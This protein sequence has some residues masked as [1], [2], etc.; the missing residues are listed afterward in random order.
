MSNAET[1]QKKLVR[2]A[3][4]ICAGEVVFFIGAGFSLDSEGNTTKLLIARLLARFDALTKTLM[5]HGDPDAKPAAE[6]LR[7]GLRKTFA[8]PEEKLAPDLFDT[9]DRGQGRGSVLDEVLTTLSQGQNYYTINDW[10]CSAFDNLVEPMLKKPPADFADTVNATEKELLARYVQ[11]PRVTPIDL[12]WLARLRDDVTV[13]PVV[14]PER[15]VCG[16]ALFLDTLGFNDENVMSGQPYHAE[17]SKVVTT[18]SRVRTRH[19]VLSWLAAEGLCPTLVTTNYDLLVDCAHRL[20]GLLPLDPSPALWCDPTSDPLTKAARLQLPLNRRYRHFTRIAEADHFFSRGDAYG[21]ATIHKIHGCVETYRTARR[22]NDV[23]AFRKVLRTIVFTFREIQNWRT[24][25]WSRDHLTTLL[26]T[27]TIVFVGYSAADQVI[28]DTFRTVYEEIAQYRREA[29]SSQPKHSPGSTAR[30]FFMDLDDVRGFHGLEILRSASTAAGDPTKELGEHPNL[31]TFFPTRRDGTQLFPTLD[32]LFTWTYHLTARELQAQALATEIHSMTYQLFRQRK[33]RQETQAIIDAFQQLRNREHED[34]CEFERGQS[35]ACAAEVRRRFERLTRWTSTWHVALMREY[36]LAESLL[37]NPTESSAIRNAARYPWYRPLS[38]HPSWTAWA[39]IL[40]LAIRRALAW[41]I[42]A[43]DHASDRW[44]RMTPDYEVVEDLAPTVLF[45]AERCGAGTDPA[46]IK[47]TLS[48]ELA[49][50][51]DRF[52]R[53]DTRR[54]FAARVPA[55]WS[56]QA[57]TVPWWAQTDDGRPVSTPSASDIWSWAALESG[58]WG[59]RTPLTF[60][61]DGDRAREQKPA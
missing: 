3:S 34:A 60:L 16:K 12:S 61:T 54:L 52:A 11:A 37:C 10:M 58:R 50:L 47:R 44:T 28:H 27:H 49:T 30:A 1:R 20:S 43:S 21:S 6:A 36:Q 7:K 51:R 4:H 18:P 25:S 40:E 19:H 39:V 31:L 55:V 56:L 8:L 13:D 41:Y 29:V 14:P 46:P 57:E 45:R 2:L 15:F 24:D 23:Q 5:A 32:D 35:A 33:P 26:R 42:C 59:A 48:I 53:N 9:T 22:A 38:E 17:L